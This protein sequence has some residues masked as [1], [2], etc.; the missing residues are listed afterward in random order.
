MYKKLS[1]VFSLIACFTINMFAQ[2]ALPKVSNHNVVAERQQLFDFNWKFFLGD[3]ASAKAIDFNDKNWRTLDLP[4]DWSIEGKVNPKNPTGGAGG[5]FPAGMGWYRKIFQAPTEW[6]GK[7][8][9]IYFE[10]V[11][12][13]AE[14]FINGKS[15]GKYPYGYSSFSYELSSHLD[16][17][18]VNVIAVRVD[19]SQQVN[20][21]WYSGSGIYRHVWMRVTNPVHIA[22]RGVAITTPDVSSKTATVQIKTVVK[23]ETALAQSVVLKTMLL[24][25]QSKNAGN[26]ETRV[27]LAANSEREIIQIILVADPLLWT[28]ETPHLYAA[29]VQVLKNK[30]VTDD[31]ETNFGIRSIKFTTEKGFQL[32][33]K[34][35]KLNGGCVHHDNGSL[36][37]A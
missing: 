8:V 13:N 18:H 27:E 33:G 32:N 2:L 36:G 23:N 11:Y 24:N 34:T 30:K 29:Q 25:A 16:F 1:I 19:N 3:T 14:V 17:N 15:L 28:P 21:R 22:D 31:T 37:A 26:N 12:M 5:Y 9:S 10:G 7:K 20:S 35:V 6:K 4:H